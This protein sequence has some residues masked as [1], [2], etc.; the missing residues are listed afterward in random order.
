MALGALHLSVFVNQLVLGLVVVELLL[1][2]GYHLEPSALVV[3]VALGARVLVIGVQAPSGLYAT[4]QLVMAVEAVPVRHAAA[5]PMAFRAVQN[6]VVLGVVSRKRP[7]A[8][9][10]VYAFPAF[11]G[12]RHRR[13]KRGHKKEEKEFEDA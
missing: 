2:E 5:E 3:A 8:Y 1:L 13:Q 9:E 7:R 4:V 10:R 12:N 6:A 11:S